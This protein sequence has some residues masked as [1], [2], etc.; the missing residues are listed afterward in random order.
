MIPGSGRSPGEVPWLPTPVF[1]SGESH[2]QRSLV[3]YTVHRAAKSQTQPKQLSKHAGTTWAYK[4][5]S[6]TKFGKFSAVVFKY[7]LLPQS[8]SLQKPPAQLL[9]FLILSTGTEAPLTFSPYFL[10]QADRFLL[11]SLALLC[12]LHPALQPVQWNFYFMYFISHLKFSV[13]FM[14]SV[15]LLRCCIFLGVFLSQCFPFSPGGGWPS[16][17]PSLTTSHRPLLPVSWVWPAH[18]ASIHVQ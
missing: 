16:C 11:S 3:G 13:F 14:A 2:R 18:S 5:M 6:F 15:S 12:H 1:L 9:G 7:F 8:L 4:F 17:I 10:S